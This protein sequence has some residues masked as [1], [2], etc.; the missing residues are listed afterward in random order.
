LI[1]RD[2]QYIIPSAETKIYANDEL[3]A[4]VNREGEEELRKAFGTM[5]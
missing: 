5:T 1:I 3:F 4:L 2:R